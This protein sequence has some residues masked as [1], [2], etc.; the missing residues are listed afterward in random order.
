MKRFLFW[1]K[2]CFIVIECS[3]SDAATCKKDFMEL[4]FVRPARMQQFT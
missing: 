2:K 4:V 3:I 1:N